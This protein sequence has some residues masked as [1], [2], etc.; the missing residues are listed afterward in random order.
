MPGA[1]SKLLTQRLPIGSPFYL[2]PPLTCCTYLSVGDAESRDANSPILNKSLQLPP[3]LAGRCRQL[4]DRE[5]LR[6][7]AAPPGRYARPVTAYR[8]AFS[9]C[10]GSRWCARCWRPW[11]TLQQIAKDLDL[12]RLLHQNATALSYLAIA[13]LFKFLILT[14]H[15]SPAR[16]LLSGWMFD[17]RFYCLTNHC[18]KNQRRR[19]KR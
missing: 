6:T 15:L 2:P 10:A 12:G 3:T 8:S 17:E 1:S 18:L 11:H 14:N 4:H 19:E 7:Q 13:R 16:G 9:G 5:P